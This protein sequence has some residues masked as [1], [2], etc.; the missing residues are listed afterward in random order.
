MQSLRFLFLPQTKRLTIKKMI[1]LFI[2]IYILWPFVKAADSCLTLVR[3]LCINSL[4]LLWF[5][6]KLVSNVTSVSS[7]WKYWKRCVQFSP[8]EDRIHSDTQHEQARQFW[9]L[10]EQLIILGAFVIFPF[11][12]SVRCLMDINRMS[13]CWVRSWCQDVVSLA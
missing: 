1:H 3:S 7:A 4:K 5:F 13:V 6:C 10:K 8:T 9:A 2:C 11:F 12:L